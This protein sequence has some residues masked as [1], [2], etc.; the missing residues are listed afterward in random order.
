MHESSLA[1]SSSWEQLVDAELASLADRGWSSLFWHT[2][3]QR[4]VPWQLL[5]ENTA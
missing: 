1:E 2:K 5:F 3:Q 4:R